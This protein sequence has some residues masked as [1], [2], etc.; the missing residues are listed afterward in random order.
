[1]KTTKHNLKTISN[2]RLLEL[3][4]KWGAAGNTNTLLIRATEKVKSAKASEDL[5]AASYENN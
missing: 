5:I 4:R 2:K 1:M 3:A